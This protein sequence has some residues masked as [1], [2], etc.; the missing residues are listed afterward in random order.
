M[1]AA[2]V[3]TALGLTV[4]APLLRPWVSM[5]VSLETVIGLVVNALIVAA[6]VYFMPN[7][8]RN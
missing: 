4:L 8:G 3:I 2:K 5:E 1:P 6:G 7:K